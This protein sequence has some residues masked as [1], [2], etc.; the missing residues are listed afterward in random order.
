[1]CLI[2]VCFILK[3]DDKA[4]S[5]DPHFIG[6]PVLTQILDFLPSHAVLEG[7]ARKLGADRYVKKF[8]AIQHLRTFIFAI[9]AR[10]HSIRELNTALAAHETKLG[11]I[12]VETSVARSTFSDANTRRSPLF[13]EEVYKLLFARYQQILSD[14]QLSQ[15][16]REKRKR[17][18]AMDSTTVPLFSTIFEGTTQE[19]IHGKR[20]GG[21]KVHTVIDTADSIP[22]F[23]H[24][25]DAIRHDSQEAQALLNLPEGSIVLIDRGYYDFALFEKLNQK[26]IHYITRIKKNIRYQILQDRTDTNQD[27]S[28][29]LDYDIK[30]AIRAKNEYAIQKEGHSCRLLAWFNPDKKSYDAYLTSLD[31]LTGED[32]HN[33]YA[34]RWKIETLFKKLKQNFNLTNFLSQSRN[35]IIIQIWCILITFLLLEM[36]HMRVK[37]RVAFSVMLADL[38]ILVMT[39]I[40][41]LSFLNDPDK[42]KGIPKRIP[43]RPP[44]PL[45]IQLE[46]DFGD[47]T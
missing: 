19:S 23:V 46:F 43:K 13:F 25:T 41:F 6:Q 12:G 42:A 16:E 36:I 2:S 7:L 17:I 5:K 33:T 18:Y 34:L 24:I 35:G 21:L 40:D 15:G 30:L 9:A 20:K 29:S 3:V 27:P 14:S 39:Y 45:P 31:D 11:H 32:I 47:T 22:L 4:M 10:V 37:R 26:G 8:T 38:S 1:M 44:S 28:T